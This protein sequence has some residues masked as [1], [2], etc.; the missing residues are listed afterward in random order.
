VFLFSVTLFVFAYA[1]RLASDAEVFAKPCGASVETLFQGTGVRKLGT[2]SVR[3]ENGEAN[4]WA[5]IEYDGQ[6]GWIPSED[7]IESLKEERGYYQPTVSS[8]GSGGDG[9]DGYGGDG[10][11][12]GYGDGGDGGYGDGG[13]G[14][15]INGD[16][17]DGSNPGSGTNINAVIDFANANWNCAQA[18]C[19]SRVHAGSGQSNYQCAEFVSRSLAAGGFIPGITATASQSAYLN[20]KYQGVTY[21]LLWVSSKQGP[22][23]GLEDL[24]IVL[25]WRNMGTSTS[26][27]H[28]ASAVMCHGTGGNY[29]HVVVGVGNNVVDAHNVARYK[30]PGSIYT[31]NAIYNPPN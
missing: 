16:G 17:G 31:I 13:D 24:L 28:A 26:N 10:G 1:N 25:G 4:T 5:F 12:G 29:H 8:P 19:T 27:I 18:S 2:R 30:E 21:D 14:A 6:R 7:M 20:Y 23:R 22:P 3:C 9:G 15:V 11:D